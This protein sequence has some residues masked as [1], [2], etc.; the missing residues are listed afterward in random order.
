MKMSKQTFFLS[1]LFGF[2]SVYLDLVCC[3]SICYSIAIYMKSSCITQTN[4]I[5]MGP[6]KR[7]SESERAFFSNR[8]RF[9]SVSLLSFLVFCLLLFSLFALCITSSSPWQLFLFECFALLLFVVVVVVIATNHVSDGKCVSAFHFFLLLL[10][11]FYFQFFL[12]CDF[13]LFSKIQ[14]HSSLSSSTA[15]DI[16]R[17][18]LQK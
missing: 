3:W 14:N 1:F 13:I 2:G 18:L 12:V 6:R 5:S 10:K 17:R 7:K 9:S 11:L 8:H 16:S 15:V 4:I